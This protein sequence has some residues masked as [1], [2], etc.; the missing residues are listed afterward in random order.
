MSKAATAKTSS[1]SDRLDQE[2]TALAVGQFDTPEFKLCFDTPLTMERARYFAL[3][4][5]FY[6][7]NRRDCW[8]Y[9][10]AKAPWEVKQAIWEHESDELHFDARGGSDHRGLMTKEAIALGMTAEE[11]AA[12]EPSPLMTAVMWGFNHINIT[13]PWL[14]A[15]TASHFLERRNNGRIVRG[16][17]FSARWRDKLVRDLKI[18]SSLLISSNVHVE[19]DMD[20]SD[21]IWDAICSHVTDEHSYQTALEG[22]RQCALADRAYR[23]AL[24]FEMRQL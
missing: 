16:G 13:L 12:S 22:G 19:A 3:Q 2:L 20:H 15:I 5:V 17:G 8:A 24:A 9:V 1:W 23:V 11:I 21:S 14:G 10:Q 18:D 4:F 6:N 7:V